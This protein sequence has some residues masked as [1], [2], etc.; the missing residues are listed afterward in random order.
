VA[1][2][3]LGGAIAFGLVLLYIDIL[4]FSGRFC[5]SLLFRPWL[6]VPPEMVAL[7]ARV[8]GVR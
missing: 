4:G 1:T 8:P 6:L 7:A 5:R 3:L 2:G